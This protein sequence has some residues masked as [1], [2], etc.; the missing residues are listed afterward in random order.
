MFKSFMDMMRPESITYFTDSIKDPGVSSIHE[1]AKKKKQV[2]V[3]TAE[4][5]CRLEDIPVKTVRPVTG[6]ETSANAERKLH[7]RLRTFAKSFYLAGKYRKVNISMP[8]SQRRNE[9]GKSALVLHA[10]SSSMDEL[11]RELIM[12]GWDIFLHE[13]DSLV[14]LGD[15]SCKKIDLTAPPLESFQKTEICNVLDR[16]EIINR[17]DLL[18]GFDLR[19]KELVVP[20]LVEFIR[21][22]CPEVLSYSEAIAEIMDEKD[23]RCCFMRDSTAKD[24]ISTII[25]AD[26][27]DDVRKI[28]LQHGNS[29]LDMKEWHIT[30]LA[31]FNEYL[32]MESV[33]REYFENASRQDYANNECRV[34]EASHYLENIKR[35]HTSEQTGKRP[36]IY[37]LAKSSR[38]VRR[39]NN[40]VYPITWYY[41]MTRRVID[42]FRSRPHMDFIVKYVPSQTWVRDSL[43]E[44]IACNAPNV[45]LEEKP[46]REYLSAAGRIILDFPGTAFFEAITAGLPVFC[47]YKDWY[48]VST[49]AKEH[50]DKHLF[51]YTELHEAFDGIRLFLDSD[52][53]EYISSVP[54][55]KGSL[56]NAVTRIQ[57]DLKA[58]GGI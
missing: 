2:F 20:Y 24:S 54:M 12:E 37:V 13:G 10:G 7:A 23:I 14:R 35:R 1:F 44:Y 4:H 28:G 16:A 53:T 50:F 51:K 58:N 5:I 19:I 43:G 8:G 21:K 25:A 6:V 33:S 18:H 36:V 41:E 57:N 56:K 55:R 49:P 45:S 17:I 32:T 15:L 42:V 48:N 3:T 46:F 30:E 47:F 40:L 27:S 22:T 29:A 38:Y 9:P 11:V 34:E 31:G 39:F 52:G 26:K